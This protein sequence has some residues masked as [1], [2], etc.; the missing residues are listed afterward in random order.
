SAAR[1]ANQ[2]RGLLGVLGVLVEHGDRRAF[3]SRARRGRPADPASASGHDHHSTF[4]RPH[5][6]A[7]AT[8]G[9]PSRVRRRTTCRASGLRLA[10][11]AE[12][13]FGDMAAASA[14]DM[15]TVADKV[16]IVTGSGKGVGRGMALHLGKGGARVVVAEWKDDLMASTCRELDDLGVENL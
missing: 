10:L 8:S 4:E 11:T 7:A 1:V 6:H 3:A 15:H 12:R 2:R 9:P 14:N 5:V 16:I 13:R